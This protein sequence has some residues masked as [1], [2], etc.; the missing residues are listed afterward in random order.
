M[1]ERTSDNDAILKQ[2]HQKI[3]TLMGRKDRKEA[4]E[5][6]YRG[7]LNYW[8]NTKFPGKKEKLKRYDMIQLMS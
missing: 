7:F 1:S 2:E 5:V 4:K 3:I 8:G 6:M